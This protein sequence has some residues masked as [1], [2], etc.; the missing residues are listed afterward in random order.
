MSTPSYS[1]TRRQNDPNIGAYRKNRARLAKERKRCSGCGKVMLYRG[2]PEYDQYS[3]DAFTAHHVVPYAVSG[4]LLGPIVAMCRA[5]NR[6]I[7]DDIVFNP[8]P[9]THTREWFT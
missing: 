4:D 9:R 8:A 5:C 7:S 2:D 3:P 1:A 6:D